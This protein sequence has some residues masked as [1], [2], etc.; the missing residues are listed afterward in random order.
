M[1]PKRTISR[2][3]GSKWLKEP[4]TERDFPSS[5]LSV[6]DWYG[7]WLSS[8]L[9]PNYQ[10]LSLLWLW[11][12][13]RGLEPKPMASRCLPLLLVPRRLSQPAALPASL[14]ADPLDWWPHTCPQFGQAVGTSGQSCAEQIVSVCVAQLLALKPCLERHN[15]H[16]QL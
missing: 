13:T 1:R 15:Q 9:C 16:K 6:Q 5:L 11:L 8:C 7:S 4:A 3:G 12:M 14:V 2:E 10:N